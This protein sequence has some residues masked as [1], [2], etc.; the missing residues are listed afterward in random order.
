MVSSLE[1][2]LRQSHGSTSGDVNSEDFDLLIVDWSNMIHRTFHGLG[3]RDDI[4]SSDICLVAEQSIR[5]MATGI[6]FSGWRMV[7]VLDGGYSGRKEIYGGY[8]GSRVGSEDRNPQ[9]VHAL[10]GPTRDQA[11][12]ITVAQCFGYEA[13][14]VMAAIAHRHS[15]NAYILSADRDLLQAVNQSTFLLVPK[16]PLDSPDCFGVDEVIEHYGFPPSMIPQYK[17]LQGDKADD[18]PQIPRIGHG[19]ACKLLVNYG[20]I[21]GAINAALSG[22]LTPKITESLILYRE[23]ITLNLRLVTLVEVPGIEEIYRKLLERIG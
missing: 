23:A 10:S 18:V 12:Q 13:D 20:N 6:L 22:K 17:A 16:G 9:L 2:T 19:T 15:G 3:A 21:E 5:S 14:D 1:I 7:I 4:P 8:K 11:S